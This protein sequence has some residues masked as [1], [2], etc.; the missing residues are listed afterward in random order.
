[1][2]KFMEVFRIFLYLAIIYI[3]T[4]GTSFS[5][6]IRAVYSNPNIEMNWAIVRVSDDRIQLTG[7]LRNAS[8]YE[9]ID[10]ELSVRTLDVA[11]EPQVATK[12]RFKPSQV[13]PDMI[14]PFGMMIDLATVES[15]KA[16]E[17]NVYYGTV[18][19]DQIILPQYNQYQWHI[20]G[21]L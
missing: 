5:E 18:G 9:M 15:V 3:S 8:P 21:K 13:A 17:F 20:P 16:L 4:T 7:K 14:M 11:G 2:N 1:M 12:F 19:Q 6:P 10:I